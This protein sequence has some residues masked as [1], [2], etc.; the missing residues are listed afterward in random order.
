MREYLELLGFTVNWDSGKQEA[1]VQTHLLGTITLKVG[2]KTGFWD[3]EEIPLLSPTVLV[4][5]RLYGPYGVVQRAL[6]LD[7][8]RVAHNILTEQPQPER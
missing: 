3:G 5:N 2:G 1:A 4:R 8:E 6:A 7:N